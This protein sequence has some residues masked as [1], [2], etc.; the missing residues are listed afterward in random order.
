MDP[1]VLQRHQWR[2]TLHSLAMLGG[3]G[4]LLGLIGYVMSGWV[5]VF[6]LTALWVVTVWFAPRI[7]PRW[8]LR[9]YGASPIYPYEAQVLYRT[10][11]ELAKRAKLPVTP[12]LYY[13]PSHAPNAVTLGDTQRPYIAISE[14]L[15]QMLSQRELR[16]VLAHEIAH[17]KNRDLKLMNLA[18]SMSRITSMISTLGKLLLFLQFP[19]LLLGQK[20]IPWLLLLLLIVAPIASRLLGLALSRVREFEAD[21]EAAQLTEDPAALASALQRIEQSQFSFWQMFWPLSRSKTTSLFHTH[22]TS[23]ERIERLLELRNR[24][25]QRPQRMQPHIQQGPVFHVDPWSTPQ[26]RTIRRVFYF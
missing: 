21:R 8:V 9:M 2:N 26:Q 23:E 18:D 20:P 10:V 16:G 4:S 19:L 5:G 3:M 6:W 15:L 12:E 25:P 17:I 14:G 1:K 24:Y 11:A 22:P 13:I 7:S